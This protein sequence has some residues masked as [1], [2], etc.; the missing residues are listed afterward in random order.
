MNA[1][2][3]MLLLP[4]YQYSYERFCLLMK[5]TLLILTSES[6]DAARVLSL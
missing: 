5:W 2:E 1:E 4:E 3:T 6:K